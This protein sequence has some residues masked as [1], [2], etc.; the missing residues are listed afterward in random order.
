[1]SFGR[2]FVLGP[3]DPAKI[4]A[5]FR[6]YDADMLRLMAD[7]TKKIMQ[8]EPT[9]TDILDDWRQRVPMIRPLIAETQAR[10]AG[11][12]RADIASA[13]ATSFEGDRIGVYREGDDQLPIIAR[14]PNAE[15]TNVDDLNNVQIWSPA[16]R[17]SIPIRQV[18]LGFETSSENT[19]VRRRDRLPTITVKCDPKVGEAAQVF[20]VLRPRIEERFEQLVAEH[21]LLGY[22]LEW[23]GEYED[24]GDAKA[25]LQAK[26][27]PIGVLIFLVVVILFNSI[28]QPLMIFLTVPLAVIGVTAGLLLTGQPFGFMAL[29]GFMSLVGMM[30]KNAIVLI[31]EINLQVSEGKEL[32]Y[33]I[34]DS[35]V[36]RM[37][38]VSMAALTTVLG[39]V[40]LLA[41][42]FFVSMAV[43]IMFGLSFATVLTLFVI[44][45]LYATFN[46]VS[47]PRD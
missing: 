34:V 24:S 31:D 42:A 9:A 25:A 17:R 14:S 30:I 38:P 10:A 18:V 16:A 28:Q 44:P 26:I 7:E 6:G 29:L 32:F 1:M 5:R 8:H 37:R 35:G 43:T 45:V 3:G 47:V 36:S 15:R 13:L 2:K 12:M 22:S 40:P 27:V 23:G 33:A 4:H 41:D 39:M 19:I 11:I 46:R 21:N 20:Q